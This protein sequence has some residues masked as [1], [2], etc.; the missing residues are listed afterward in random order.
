MSKS[1][2]TNTFAFLLYVLKPF[3]KRFILF[4]LCTAVA[5]T[6]FT[7]SPF[8]I[9]NLINHIV[10]SRVLDN[11]VWMYIGL[12]A[13]LRFTDEWFWRIGEWVVLKFLPELHELVR[14]TL[15]KATLRK[16]HHFFVNANSGQIGF[17]INNAAEKV[18]SVVESTIW[19]IWNRRRY[20]RSAHQTKWHLCGLVAPPKRR[21][22]GGVAQS[23]GGQL[24]CYKSKLTPAWAAAVA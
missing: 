6:S 7:A 15:F 4:F 10:D 1:P 24:R 13:L 21:L 5:L 9:R 18:R 14:S 19:S 11:I 23:L 22:F 17:W 8:V 3:R 20:T 16:E 2:P 12:F